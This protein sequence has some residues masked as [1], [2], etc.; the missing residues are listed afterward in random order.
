M[1]CPL[2]RCLD[3]HGRPGAHLLLLP[4]PPGPG[5]SEPRADAELRAAVEHCVLEGEQSAG[6]GGVAGETAPV[7]GVRGR[8]VGMFQRG[9]S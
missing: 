7:R 6:L 4:P 5:E 9:G 2:C 1:S 8:Q 3:Q